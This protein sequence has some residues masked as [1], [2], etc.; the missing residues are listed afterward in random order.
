MA[1]LIGFGEVD[2]L[3]GDLYPSME[4]AVDASGP[5]TG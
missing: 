5:W 4:R 2:P 1:D 3:D